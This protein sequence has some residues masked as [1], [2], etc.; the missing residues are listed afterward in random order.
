MLFL[1]YK[2]TLKIPTDNNTDSILELLNIFQ[3]ITSRH[4]NIQILMTELLKKTPSIYDI[5]TRGNILIK[6]LSKFCDRKKENNR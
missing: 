3:G 1:K 6:K 2:R 5:I 4:Q